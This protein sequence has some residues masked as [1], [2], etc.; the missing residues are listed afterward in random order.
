MFSIGVNRGASAVPY[1]PV[2]P[3]LQ[4][5][6]PL[7]RSERNLARGERLLR[8][9]G[10]RAYV[11]NAPR[12]GRGEILQPLPACVSLFVLYPGVRFAHPRLISLRPVG[13]EYVTVFTKSCTKL[14]RVG[15]ASEEEMWNRFA[16]SRAGLCRCRTR[17]STRIR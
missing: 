1:R 16:S 4:S 9:P 15:A 11:T 12:Q 5:Y 13:A 8:T 6:R 10:T 3:P 14:R 2:R 7:R 17:M